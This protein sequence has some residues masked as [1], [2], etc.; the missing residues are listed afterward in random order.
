MS[1]N[2]LQQ[3]FKRTQLF[4]R[5]SLHT[6]IVLF[7]VIGINVITTCHREAKSSSIVYIIVQFRVTSYETRVGRKLDNVYIAKYLQTSCDRAGIMGTGLATRPPDMMG[8]PV[9]FCDF[10]FSK[11]IKTK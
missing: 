8:P 5:E 9:N 4:T 2:H 6:I 11:A 10:L 7:R 1:V 3:Y